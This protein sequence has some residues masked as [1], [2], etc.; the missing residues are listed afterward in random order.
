L[1][2]HP[3]AVAA[4]ASIVEP[5]FLTHLQSSTLCGRFVQLFGD[6]CDMLLHMLMSYFG[7]LHAR[8]AFV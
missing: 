1:A 2:S 3:Q 7:M 8:L 5:R 4:T 6:V